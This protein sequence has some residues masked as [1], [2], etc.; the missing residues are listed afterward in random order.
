MTKNSFVAE[1]TFKK[2]FWRSIT[3]FAWV[4]LAA[5]QLPEN[6][7]WEILVGCR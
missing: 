5:A 4:T 3:I 2:K 1:V 7:H 6:V